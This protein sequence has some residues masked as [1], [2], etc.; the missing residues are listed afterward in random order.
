MS[1]HTG[2]ARRSCFLAVAATAG[3]PVAGDLSRAATTAAATATDRGEC[4]ESGVRA[5]GSADIGGTARAARADRGGVTREIQ[6]RGPGEE[7]ARAT[8]RAVIA[9]ATAAARDEQIVDGLVEIDGERARQGDGVGERGDGSSDEETGLADR[10]GAGAQGGVMIGPDGATGDRRAPGVGVRTGQRDAAAGGSH[11]P[12][13]ADGARHDDQVGAGEGQDAVVDDGARAE[14]SG[15]GAIADAQGARGN[16]RRARVGV[17][18]REGQRTRTELGDGTRTADDSAVGYVTG[19]IEDQRAAVGHGTRDG[20]GRATR[21]DAQRA[22]ADRRTTRI[23]VVRLQHRDARTRLFDAARTA[24]RAGDIERAGT[25]EDQRA[26]VGDRTRTERARGAARADAHGASRDI[27]GADVGVG[28]RQDD[29]TPGRDGREV[30]RAGD[31][32]AERRAERA[33]RE[34][35]GTRRRE[36]VEGITRGRA[37]TRSNRTAGTGRATEIAGDDDARAAGSADATVV[38]GAT[39]LPTTAAAAGIGRAGAAV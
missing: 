31:R 30:A 34:R 39:G 37:R 27:R 25:V 13:A 11:R 26:V 1:G 12:G 8:A 4:I 7:T 10:Q 2:T 22:G 19:T 33:Q 17:C 29:R 23:S 6:G 36:S 35:R 16:R 3:T 28:A 21:S 18:S 5:I 15:G 14:T 38:C 32:A 9:T 20:A 24:D